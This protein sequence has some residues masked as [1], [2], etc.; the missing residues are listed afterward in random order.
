MYY[1]TTPDAAIRLQH[2]IEPP[3]FELIQTNR[4]QAQ[5]I[6][7]LGGEQKKTPEYVM[8]GQAY[9]LGQDTTERVLHGMFLAK[10]TGIP[11]LVSGGQIQTPKTE[12]EAMAKFMWE[13]GGPKPQWIENLSDSTQENAKF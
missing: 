7:I 2:F 6:V 10:Q 5:A 4:I 12:A 9:K 8:W 1:S 11:V 13:Y 3:P